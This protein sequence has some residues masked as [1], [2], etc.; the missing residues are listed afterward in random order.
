MC[1]PG[2][3]K[4]GGTPIKKRRIYIVCQ[5]P[6]AISPPGLTGLL[7]ERHGK[8]SCNQEFLFVG[9]RGAASSF[10]AMG[11]EANTSEV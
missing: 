6:S 7:R 2:Q 8:D 10:F 5:Y 9:T 3:S 4:Q 1:G 11:K